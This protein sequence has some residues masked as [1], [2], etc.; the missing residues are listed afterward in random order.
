VPEEWKISHLSTIHKKGDKKNCDNYRGIAVTS[1]ISRIYGK[2]LKSR[3]E[4]EY[5]DM[6]AEEQAGFRARKINK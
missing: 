1:S 3:I 4:R 6:E 5:A 2:T